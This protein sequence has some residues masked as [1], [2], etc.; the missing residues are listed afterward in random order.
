MS[1]SSFSQK[2]WSRQVPQLLGTYLAVGFGMLQF[3]EFMTSRYDFS[4][5]WVDRYLLL[6][7]GLIP[8]VALLIYYRGFP[9][10][11][12]GRG[13]KRSLLGVNVLIVGFCAF[14][15][16]GGPP[17][18]ETEVVS[19]VDETGLAT[20]RVIP[21]SSSVQRIAIF[22]FTSSEDNAE[23]KWWGTA[24]GLLL[25][26]HLQQRPEIL[27]TTNVA[28]NK[29][30]DR[31]GAKKF[32]PIN[33]ATQRR[34]AERAQTDFFVRIEYE[35]SPDGH[36]ANGKLY[37]TRDGKPVQTL[38][39]AAETVYGVVDQLKAQ[40]VDYLPTLDELNSTSTELPADA[41]ITDKPKALESY[42]NGV[43]AFAMNAGELD[44]P[45]AFYRDCFRIDPNCAAC[46]ISLADILYGQGKKDS[47]VL[48]LRQATR[49]AEVL[50]ERRQ[51]NYKAT[52]LSVEGEY[53]SLARLMEDYRKVYPYEYYPYSSLQGYYEL[54][55]GL[56]SAIHLMQTAALVS[57]REKALTAVY[58]LQLDAEDFVGAE[59]TIKDLQQEFPDEEM[60]NRRY[61]KF[62]EKSGQVEKARELIK[63][64]MAMDPM[65]IDLPNQLLQIEQSAGNFEEVKRLALK[66]MKKASSR[67]D[68][69]TAWNYLIRSYAGAGQI[70]RALSELDAY[71]D[72]LSDIVP[73]NIFV[74]RN[75]GTRSAYLLQTDD[76]AKVYDYLDEMATY[77]P[78]LT[79]VYYCYLPMQMIE[80]GIKEEDSLAK[81]VD[82]SDELAAISPVYAKLGEAYKAIGRE[83]FTTGVDIIE[84]LSDNKQD[85]LSPAISAR[86]NRLAGRY[87]RALELINKALKTQQ[88]DPIVL[89][90]YAMIKHS[91]GDLTTAKK[92]LT[93]PLK[94][95]ADADDNFRN[96]RKA[97]D[98]A[99][100]LGLAVQ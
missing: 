33:L 78:A 53:E 98:L 27:T 68:S 19:I 66:T 26:D 91:M 65:N 80:V 41:L 30:Y 35:I 11:G 83:D 72:F 94:T 96:K 17:E 79:E 48:L 100:E 93:I 89:L 57:D 22:D 28:L 29:Q 44:T 25:N 82:C 1:D 2:L 4:G 60:S 90:E 88:N 97:I 69:T 34:I 10:A 76:Y 40:I 32:E 81:L 8:A 42:V 54:N 31:F 63:D 6:W 18:A 9:P 36:E 7:L 64:M 67:T 74:M 47:S 49:L 56:D 61:A 39:G 45:A 51:Y 86:F 75:Y 38:Q 85:V 46:A 73:R 23:T 95:W 13:W 24:Y 20:Q 5:A 59:N 12:K 62:Y 15:L 3:V 77:D 99:E 58:N 71:E 92:A 52:L 87:D 43:I 16:P 55:Y 21:A 70:N 50:P 37:R 84:E 14:F